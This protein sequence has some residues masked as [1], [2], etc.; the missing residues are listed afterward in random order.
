MAAAVVAATAE[1]VAH[2]AA[3]VAA[4]AEPLKETTVLRAVPEGLVAHTEV[5]VEQVALVVVHLAIQ[6]Q[7]QLTWN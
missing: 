4:E 2:M 1:T 6:E 5:V 7:T 3:V